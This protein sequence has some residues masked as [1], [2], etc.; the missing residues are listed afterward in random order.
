MLSNGANGE[1]QNE[2]KEVLGYE[3]FTQDEIN[4]YNQ[5]LMKN[6]VELDKTSTMSIAN[7]FKTHTKQKYL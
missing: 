1:T 6:L 3:K 7:S 2:I 4:G 5:K